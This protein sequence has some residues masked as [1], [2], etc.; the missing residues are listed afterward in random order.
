M[1]AVLQS[2]GPARVGRFKGSVCAHPT[3]RN[4][5]GAGATCWVS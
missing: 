1:L 2:P 4:P 3:P 5:S